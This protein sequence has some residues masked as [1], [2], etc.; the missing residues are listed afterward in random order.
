[1][2]F[3]N[4]QGDEAFNILNQVTFDHNQVLQHDSMACS[5]IHTYFETRIQASGHDLV[6]AGSVGRPPYNIGGWPPLSGIEWNQKQF[7]VAQ[8]MYPVSKLVIV[9]PRIQWLQGLPKHV[10]LSKR[11][12]NSTPQA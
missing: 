10:L 8:M 6:A 9:T 5:N 4:F 12:H 11:Q 1:M 2:A 7:N 3:Y